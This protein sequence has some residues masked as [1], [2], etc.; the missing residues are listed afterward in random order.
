M[1]KKRKKR[2]LA[3]L[4]LAFTLLVSSITANAGEMNVHFLDVGQGLS[5]LVQCDGHNMVYDGGDRSTSSYV[6]SYLQNQ[7]VETIDYLIS[8]HYD[9]DHMAGLIG[10]LN[11]FN[12][13]NVIGSDY[14]H[15]SDLYTSFMNA[16]A[17]DGLVV[18]HPAVGETFQ[19]GSATFEILGPTYIS[20]DSNNNSVAIKL[21]NEDD[22]FVFTGDA[23]ADEEAEMIN[24]GIDLD[25]EVLV[26][27]HHGSDTSTSWDFLAA[28]APVYAVISCGTDNQY[29]HPHADTLEKMQSMDI[30]IF[31]TDDQGTIVATSN[32][33]TILFNVAPST[34]YA[35]GDEQYGGSAEDIQEE[36][37]VQQ[38]EN[39]QSD[40]GVGQL[41]WLS[42]TGEKYHS[43]NNCGRMNPDKAR[44]VTLS[45]AES[46]GYERCKKCW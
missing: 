21:V 7:G 15:D 32:G 31:R 33:S 19:L 39:I 4:V 24:T 14:V 43:R 44:Q 16:V 45:E 17:S 20:S 28:T 36:T 22:S 18:Q 25:C 9:S 10:C 13:N 35:S 27:G 30:G 2:L 46:Q 42:A 40:T 38:I 34:N 1:M 8:S 23:E 29:G 6:V 26:L 12:V 41:V 3:W 11:A 5:I 37:T